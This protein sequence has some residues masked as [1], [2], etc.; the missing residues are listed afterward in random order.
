MEMN[1]KIA[2][3]TGAGRRI[4]HAVALALARVG[5]KVVVHYRESEEQAELTAEEVRMLGSTAWTIQAD[6]LDHEQ[7]DGLIT[8][9]QKL[10]GPVEV[11]VNNASIFPQ[12]SLLDMDG[13]DLATNIQLHGLAPLVLSRSVYAQGVAASIVNLLDTR[14]HDYDCDHAA[15]HLSK[16]MLLSLT[17]MMALEFS[18]E[19]RVNAVAPG[20][21]LPPPGMTEDYLEAR[22]DSNPL[23]EIGTVEEVAEAVVYLARARFIT[24]EVLHIDGGRH[25]KDESM[26]KLDKIHI[27]DLALRCIVGIYDWER[28]E[29]QDV[30]INITLHADLRAAGKSDQ[31]DDTVDYKSLKKEIIAMVEASGFGLIEALAEAISDICLACDGVEQVTVGVDKPGALR[32]AR[33]VAVEIFRP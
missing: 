2:L 22:R 18:P 1:G 26:N 16:R 24:G 23:K 9:V 28:K 19:V 8:R 21:I 17:K 6:L 33:S 27:R 29:K 32:F 3:V 15:Y 31:L 20:L 10:A 11:L 7:V 12:S 4:G 14:V 30:L 5:A 13:L 25:L